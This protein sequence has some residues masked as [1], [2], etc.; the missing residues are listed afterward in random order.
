MMLEIKRELFLRG[1]SQ[2][3]TDWA[4]SWPYGLVATA[5]WDH[6]VRLWR[7]DGGE[8]VCAMLGH[9]FAARAVAFSPDGMRLVSGGDDEA[10]RVWETGSGREVRAIRGHYHPDFTSTIWGL[11][12]SADSRRMLSAASDNSVRL[13]SLVSGMQEAVF[14]HPNIV[15]R[16]LFAQKNRQI[17]S[18]CADGRIRL[19]DI[20]KETEKCV[21]TAHS[22]DAV[23]L[24]LNSSEDALASGGTDCMVNLWC[25][26]TGG[27]LCKLKGHTHT[28]GSV[29]F[30][31]TTSILASSSENGE[32]K[33]WD[34]TT[35]SEVYSLNAGPFIVRVV[36]SGDGGFL[37]VGYADG[38]FELRQAI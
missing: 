12:I 23:C 5:S 28:V 24:A 16:A 3:I 37:L 15:F 29:A 35:G 34:A 13:W 36:F 30:S 31:P 18:A 20:G 22:G 11:S 27:L 2:D 19:W 9:D 14:P 32:I 10:I 8:P 1:H 21:F 33:L 4:I 38:K 6:S 7:L 25:A 17:A 26:G